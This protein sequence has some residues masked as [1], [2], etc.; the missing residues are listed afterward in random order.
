[1]EI[2]EG[3]LAFGLMLVMYWAGYYDGN[4]TGKN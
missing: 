3:L 2:W 4:R 1:M